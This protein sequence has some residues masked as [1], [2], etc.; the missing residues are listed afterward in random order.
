MLL[1]AQEALLRAPFLLCCPY[2]GEHRTSKREG[3]GL[4][5]AWPLCVT[6]RISQPG[7]PRASCWPALGPR[8]G[9]LG[10]QH[11][12]LISLLGAA[13][14]ESRQHEVMGDAHLRVDFGS[15]LLL[16][17]GE[18]LELSMELSRPCL[19]CTCLCPVSPSAVIP[20][21]AL[22]TSHHGPRHHALALHRAFAHTGS[23]L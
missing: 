12:L 21:L 14:G 2:P 19:I 7:N 3:C 5:S 1:V 6:R 8:G 23:Y 18:N 4:S 11:Q 15:S 9:F 20:P 17:L 22:A 13:R 10:R 16:H